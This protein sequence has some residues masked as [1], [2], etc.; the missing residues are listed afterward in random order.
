MEAVRGKEDRAEPRLVSLLADDSL[1]S[2]IDDVIEKLTAANALSEPRLPELGVKLATRT[3]ERGAVKLG[4]ALLGVTARSE[5]EALV[6]TLGKHEELT[7]YSAVALCNMLPQPEQALW[8]LAK[9]VDGWGRIEVVERLVPVENPEIKAWLWREGFRNSIMHEYLAHIAAVHGDLCDALRNEDFDHDD[10]VSVSDLILALI[11][12]NGGPALGMDDYADAGDACRLYLRHARRHTPDLRH[13][14]TAQAI[15]EYLRADERDAA[16]KLSGGWSE[17][18]IESIESAATGFVTS[19][20]WTGLVERGLRSDDEME[21]DLADEAARFVD[22]DPYEH[23]WTRL[24]ADPNDM[25]RWA[26]VMQHANESRISEIV[27]FAE[28][29]IP[30]DEIA[31][32]AAD[33]T[34]LGPEF[35]DHGCLDWVLQDLD[36]YPGHGWTLIKTGLKSPVVRHRNMALNAIE[37]WG[38]ES[39][40]DETENVLAQA[41]EVETDESLRERLTNLLAK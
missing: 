16:A 9:C 19:E 28:A 38:R 25:L 40:P 21:F 17:A 8:N 37:E 33:E 5:H 2:I 13:F 10:L 30:L 3:K 27:S 35:A 6:V 20:R 23:H 14:L 12:G 24:R 4:I 31:S 7:L 15:L 41:M 11:R 39:W 29:Q 32:G 18:A 22:I 26:R 1:F 36:A 34:G